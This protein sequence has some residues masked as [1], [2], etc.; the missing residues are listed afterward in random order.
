MKSSNTNESITP[1]SH[2]KLKHPEAYNHRDVLGLQAATKWTI[3]EEALH[4]THN[5]ILQPGFLDRAPEQFINDAK[6]AKVE[7]LT[8]FCCPSVK[9][10]L[11]LNISAEIVVKYKVTEEALNEKAQE[12]FQAVLK[13]NP[14]LEAKIQ[15]KINEQVKIL[16]NDSSLKAQ[17]EEYIEKKNA[18]LAQKKQMPIDKTPENQKAIGRMLISQKKKDITNQF[19][20]EELQKILPQ[21]AESLELKEKD[22]YQIAET[23]NYSFLGAAGSGKSTIAR[24]WLNDET[25]ANYA[26]LA[27][28]NYRA[29]I[30]PDTQEHEK[31]KD[32]KE[33]TKDVFTRTQDMAYLVKEL[34][35]KRL[36][37]M[38]KAGER[39]N[40]IFDGVTLEWPARQLIQ[41]KGNITSVIAAYTGEPG[42]V[43]IAERADARA[44]A[45]TA[46]PADKG[47]FANTTALLQGHATAS[48]SLLSNIPNKTETKIYDTNI[49]RGSTPP[50]IATID[51][52]NHIMEISNLRVMSEFLNKRNI[53]TE[54]ITPVGLIL[55]GQKGQIKPEGNK[56]VI[57]ILMTHPEMKAKSILDL[58]PKVESNGRTVKEPYTIVLKDKEEKPYLE[59]KANGE[60]RV[61]YEILD[62]DIFM[63][64]MHANTI[65]SSVLRATVRQIELG[66]L[67]KSLEQVYNKGDIEWANTRFPASQQS[68]QQNQEQQQS[69]IAPST[70]QQS[71]QD[72]AV[73]NEDKLSEGMKKRLQNL[74]DSLR[75]N[76]D[77]RLDVN[78]ASGERQNQNKQQDRVSVRKSKGALGL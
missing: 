40:I 15:K 49:E 32:E 38:D 27:T 77:Q 57:G 12:M 75:K 66:S 2:Q 17:V 52:T 42:F 67:E 31:Q 70:Q 20:N 29:F 63:Q 3:S 53:N 41:D 51:S 56:D 50:V 69:Q 30:M 4:K 54:A 44:K 72:F 35:Y 43:G 28:D 9:A 10:S 11:M 6:I 24:Q 64:K 22:T 18:E 25:K 8:D 7:W 16:E 33:K 55:D 68:Q 46:A 78:N 76:N 39:P 21:I 26:I 5:R 71:Q 37:D 1:Q 61:E 34:V 62:N 73:P 47:R 45:E 59:L 48:A 23:K 36:S 14:E 60:G 58:V 65:E 19:V 13:E 74:R